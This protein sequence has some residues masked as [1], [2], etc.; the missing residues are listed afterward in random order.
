MAHFEHSLGKSSQRTGEALAARRR[1]RGSAVFVALGSLSALSLF[2][3]LEREAHGKTGPCP[4]DMVALAGY[5]IDRY[6]VHMVDDKSGQRLSPFYAPDPRLLRLAYTYWA[7]ELE[8]SSVGRAREV[9]LPP[10][11][12][13]QRGDFQPRAVS[14]S[15]VLPQG[16][17]T[18]H[19]ARQACSRAGKRL[20][21][22]L[23][24][25]AACRSER[26]TKHP[27]GD[28]F[29]PGRCNVF[30][31]MH[32]AYELHG[33][34]S[35]GHLD[36]RLHLVLEEGRTPMLLETGSLKGCVSAH[37]ADGVYDMV[38]NLDEWIENPEGTFVGGFYARATR[39]GCEAKIDSHAAI[40][41]DYSLGARCC[42][43]RRPEPAPDK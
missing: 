6:E 14:R 29:E 20:C 34:S 27:Y 41:T 17:L 43:D 7:F 2:P 25:V 36:P 5:C 16:Y 21:T 3:T 19:T 31:A 13:I 22:E 33:N 12:S 39:E 11:P 38:G 32:P 42:S 35:V 24:W 37:G 26:G 1:A 30:R 4:P 15:G 40:Y 8:R 28:T 18:Y 10:V 23:E 9:A